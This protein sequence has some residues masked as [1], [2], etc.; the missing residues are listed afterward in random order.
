MTLKYSHNFFQN[1]SQ[2]LADVAKNDT[3]PTTY[4]SGPTKAADIHWHAQE[5]HVYILEGN[6]YFMD[7]E[8]NIKTPVKA[9]DKIIVPARNLHAEGNVTDMVIYII[10]MPEPL[11]PEEFLVQHDPAS[12]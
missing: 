3:W 7:A 8:N 1:K 12:L 11:L 10:A 5:A 2:V 6:T 4:V 9:G